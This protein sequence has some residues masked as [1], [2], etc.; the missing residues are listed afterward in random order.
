MQRN[1]PENPMAESVLTK[2]MMATLFIEI[3]AGL[4]EP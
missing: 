1:C 3:N 2:K 4:K